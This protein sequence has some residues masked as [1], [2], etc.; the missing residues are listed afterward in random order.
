MDRSSIAEDAA[1]AT[2]NVTATVTGGTTYA[3]AITIRVKVGE[4]TDSALEGT[5][6]A[7]VADFDLTLD[8]T[9][10]SAETTFSLDPM[11]DALDEDS[12]TLSVTGTAGDITI[13]PA[14]LHHHRQ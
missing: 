6:Y 5:D 7:N 8:A 13:T 11:D 3:S 9:D 4:G 2:V 14:R 10:A 1:T 12:E